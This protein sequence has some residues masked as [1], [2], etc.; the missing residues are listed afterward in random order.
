[1]TYQYL[2]PD[3]RMMTLGQLAVKVINGR[4]G[5]ALQTDILR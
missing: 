1:V 3:L 4:L 2:D 5:A